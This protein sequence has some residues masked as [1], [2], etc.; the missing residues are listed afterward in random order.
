[1]T[2]EIKNVSPDRE[3]VTTRIVNAKR[4]L[5]Y[6]AWSEPQHLK[7]WWG[8][9]GF[10]NTFHEFDLRPGGKW[11]FTMHGPNNAD[12]PNESVF[13]TIDPPKLLVFDHITKPEF[14]IVASFDEI[15]GSGT[16]V[17]F[18]MIFDTAEACATLREFV[19]EKNE[20]NMDRLEAE[21]KRMSPGK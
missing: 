11:I 4:E 10:T 1:M 6:K 2:S 19:T 9:N 14:Q 13:V 17:N 18:R 3:V 21:L 15:P 16:K 5:V 12:Y 20:E 8:P 7:N